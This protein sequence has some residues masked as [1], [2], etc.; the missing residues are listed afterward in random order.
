MHSRG[1][2]ASLLVAFLSRSCNR[3]RGKLQHVAQGAAVN[4]VRQ[5]TAITDDFVGLKR[6]GEQASAARRTGFD[7]QALGVWASASRHSGVTG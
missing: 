5:A 1:V 2:A 4:A 7:I 6:S 3:Q